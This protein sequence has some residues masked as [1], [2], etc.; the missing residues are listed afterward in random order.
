MFLS[1]SQKVRISDLK[2]ELENAKREASQWKQSYQILKDRHDAMVAKDVIESDFV[3]NFQQMNAFAIERNVNDG[4]PCTIVGYKIINSE[5]N[6]TVKEWYLYCSMEKHNQL[7]EEFRK[8]VK[9]SK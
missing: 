8:Y 5:G 9:G 6:E 1:L 7:A 2:V 3:C 4:R